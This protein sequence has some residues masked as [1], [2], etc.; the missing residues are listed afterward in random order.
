MDISIIRAISEAIDIK[1][2]KFKDTLKYDI[3]IT[4]IVKVDHGD[5]TFTVTINGEDSICGA[6][7]GL[8]L[9]V[10]DVVYIRCVQGNHGRKFIDCKK[11]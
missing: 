6:R 3:T 7:E 11:V 8:D 9:K 10:G 2:Q 5:G 4:G 1:L